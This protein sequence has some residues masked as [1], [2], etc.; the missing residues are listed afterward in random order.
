MQKQGAHQ[1]EWDW[2]GANFDYIIDN[3]TSL[4]GLN[5]NIDQFVNQLQGR[6]SSNVTS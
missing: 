4:E 6:P 1:S 5:A 2:I 3:T